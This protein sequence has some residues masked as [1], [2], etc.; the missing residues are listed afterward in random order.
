MPPIE[1]LRQ[2]FLLGEM[3]NFPVLFAP[4]NQSLQAGGMSRQSVETL[5]AGWPPDPVESEIIPLGQLLELHNF[6]CS[7]TF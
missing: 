3:K 2:G 6:Y 5:R 1:L 4:R 7:N